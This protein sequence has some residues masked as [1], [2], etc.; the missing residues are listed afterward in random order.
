MVCKVWPSAL[1]PLNLSSFW[2]ISLITCSSTW[3]RLFHR[4]RK[5]SCNSSTHKC[6]VVIFALDM[7]LFGRRNCRS[8]A[9]HPVLPL[10]LTITMHTFKVSLRRD[11]TAETFCVS[12]NQMGIIFISVLPLERLLPLPPYAHNDVYCDVCRR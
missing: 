6:V 4:Q 8:V 12:V 2:P 1:W 5:L 10:A 7:L 9:L 3:N 11:K